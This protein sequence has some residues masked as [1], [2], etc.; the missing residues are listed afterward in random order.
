MTNRT[1]NVFRRLLIA[2]A[3]VVCPIRAPRVVEIDLEIECP[4]C[5]RAFE[6]CGPDHEYCL[7]CDSAVYP[8]H[9]DAGELRGL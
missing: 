8:E 3:R 5:G 1:P 9:W 6:P 7:D 4:E 2:L